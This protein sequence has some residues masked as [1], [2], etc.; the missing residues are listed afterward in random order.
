MVIKKIEYLNGVSRKY[1][2]RSVTLV[3][4][5]SDSESYT[6]EILNYQPELAH[7]PCAMHKV[8]RD[9]VSV[10]A[11]AL[12]RLSM[13]S[14][15]ISIMDMLGAES[16]ENLLQL[17]KLAAVM[18][19]KEIENNNSNYS[20]SLLFLGWYYRHPILFRAA[21]LSQP[22]QITIPS[23]SEVDAYN[24]I[25]FHAFNDLNSSIDYILY[26]ISQ[27]CDELGINLIVALNEH[28]LTYE[29]DFKNFGFEGIETLDKT[30]DYLLRKP[31]K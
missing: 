27:K 28:N 2:N 16:K 7:I 14:T 26:I 6:L 29:Q 22:T 17:E 20:P 4:K 9:K 19:E 21:F 11:V 25:L 23:D 24:F 15:A 5:D 13:I 12:T 1:K 3:K 18:R 10:N 31:K 30:K 8:L